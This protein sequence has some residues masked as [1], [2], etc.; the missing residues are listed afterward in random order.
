MQEAYLDNSATTRPY[1]E[2]VQAVLAAM[3]DNYGNPSSL[4]RK[5]VEAG[6]AVARAR[7]AVAVSLGVE[8]SSIIFTGAGSEA[9]NLAI[10]GLQPG[11]KGRHI[12]TTAVE[13]PAVLNTCEQL[14]EQGLEISVLPVDT[15]GLVDTKALLQAVREDTFLVSVM[16]VNNEVGAVQPLAEISA[17]IKKLRGVGRKLFWHVD[18]VQ[19]YGKLPLRPLELGI[20]LLSVSAHK[21][22]GPKGVGAL[23]AAPGTPL[24]PLVSGGGQEWGLR[25]GT[26]NVP[27]IAGFGVAAGI[28]ARETRE[29]AAKL[30]ALK[31]RLVDGVLAAVPGAVLNGPACREDEP[32]CAPHIAN[33]SFPGLRGEVLLHSLEGQGVYVSTGSACSSRK[34]PGSYVLRAMGLDEKLVEGAVRFSLSALNTAE[35]IDYAVQAT[36][37]VVKE[38]RELYGE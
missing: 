24:K 29:A 16:Y 11:R 8:A 28:I 34:K 25:S 14:K 35:E 9:I 22:H 27:G 31:K 10:K 19:A 26:E 21:V 15:I 3:E 2:V 37:K 32:G 4:H 5:G 12:I 20:D 23:Y 7:E 6:R 17:V 36:A 13:H 38:L 1:P 18:A 30:F 33:I